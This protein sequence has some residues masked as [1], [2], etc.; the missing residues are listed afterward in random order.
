MNKGGLGLDNTTTTLYDRERSKIR[1]CDISETDNPNLIIVLWAD[2]YGDE[3]T[4]I[5]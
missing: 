2:I 5:L 1:E 4:T 3:R